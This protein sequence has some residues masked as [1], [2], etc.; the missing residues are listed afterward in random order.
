MEY[1]SLRRKGISGTLMLKF[2]RDPSSPHYILSID[3]AVIN[4]AINM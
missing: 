1:S 4:P 2:P 3:I